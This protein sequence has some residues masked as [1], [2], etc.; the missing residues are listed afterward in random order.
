MKFIDVSE[1]LINAYKMVNEVV[2]GVSR[3]KS[4]MVL[5]SFTQF[6]IFFTLNDNHLF[7]NERFSLAA[8]S[9]GISAFDEIF[10][11]PA[12]IFYVFFYLG[13]TKLILPKGTTTFSIVSYVHLAPKYEKPQ[14]AF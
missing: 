6:L 10:L 11:P 4:I 1:L 13:Y 8:S 14:N 5:S 9:N 2:L 7:K 12:I 3:W